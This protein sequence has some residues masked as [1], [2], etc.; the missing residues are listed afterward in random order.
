M[1]KSESERRS[2]DRR[3][4]EGVGGVGDKC[5][6]SVRATR[7]TASRTKMFRS[8]YL[9]LFE[10]P[11]WGSLSRRCV[12]N[13]RGKH[14]TTVPKDSGQWGRGGRHSNQRPPLPLLPL[15]R[16]CSLVVW[17]FRWCIFCDI[18]IPTVVVLQY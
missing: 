8:D 18:S 9:M 4:R 16:S 7:C 11:W 5:D 1:S 15:P 13:R 12:A 10:P 3:G 17:C 14:A 6:R 2:D